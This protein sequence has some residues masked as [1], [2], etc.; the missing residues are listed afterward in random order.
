MRRWGAIHRDADATRV[1]DGDSELHLHTGQRHR[2]A[3]L[4]DKE[5]LVGQLLDEPFKVFRPVHG[6]PPKAR[7]SSGLPERESTCGVAADDGQ[8]TNDVTTGHPEKL[9]QRS[10]LLAF[11]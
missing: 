2:H 11:R 5:W 1:V 4:A 9:T 3:L 7:G 6:S 8:Q 10:Q